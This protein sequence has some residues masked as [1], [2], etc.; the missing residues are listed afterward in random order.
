MVLWAPWCAR[1]RKNRVTINSGKAVS[2]DF[3]H[4]SSGPES[5]GTGWSRV[6]MDD[7]EECSTTDTV[8]SSRARSDLCA[9]RVTGPTLPEDKTHRQRSKW[10]VHLGRS[11]STSLSHS[12]Y[13]PTIHNF[14][15]P[16]LCKSLSPNLYLNPVFLVFFLLL[17]LYC[18]VER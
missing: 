8:T 5:G 10:S 14:R 12:L 3:S 15:T 9:I 11:S 13:S 18:I 2:N 1:G 17:G 6:V 4:I 16:R 7:G